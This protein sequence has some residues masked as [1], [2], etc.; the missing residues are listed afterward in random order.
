MVPRFKRKTTQLPTKI[1]YAPIEQYSLSFYTKYVAWVFNRWRM[2]KT[3][4][5]T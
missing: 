2:K 3:Q 1:L 4:I 5:Y